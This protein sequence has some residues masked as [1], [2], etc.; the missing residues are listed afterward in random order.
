MVVGYA[1]GN[2]N[3]QE[4]DIQVVGE[5]DA[6]VLTYSKALYLP[7]T[8]LCANDC[9]YCAFHKKDNLT[10]PYS[11]IRICKAARIKN[12]R[13]VFYVAG[14]RPDKFSQVR[15]TLDIWGFSSYLDYL[16]TV[17]ELGFL[18]GLIPVT[19]VGYMSASEMRRMREVV[20]VAKIMLDSVDSAQYAKVYPNS[21]GKQWDVRIKLLENAGKVQLPTATGIMV[22]IGESKDHRKSAIKA[23]CEMHK[24]YGMIHEV[25][26]Q[27]FVPQ[28][29]TRFGGKSATSHKDMLDTVEMAMNFLPSDVPVSVPVELNSEH[30]GDFIKAGVRDFGR[31]METGKRHT[32][33]GFGGGMEAFEAA[34]EA[35][36]FRTQQRFPLRFPFIRD[37]HYSKKLGQV[38]DAFRYKIKKD[39]QEKIKA[40]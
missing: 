11:T 22:G 32:G 38:F 23:I 33:T 35:A 27:N 40:T 5:N 2:R 25:L 17:C 24:Q 20:A 36:G 15:S 39:E 19:E 3:D 4:G 30:L 6:D 37:G 16:Y 29:G 8:R 21:P 1:L 18:E 26:I 13:E 31:I 28:P 34:A 12:I 14:E 10:V 7:I 9:P